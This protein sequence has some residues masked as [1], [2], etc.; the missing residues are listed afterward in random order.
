MLRTKFRVKVLIME[1]KNC[2]QGGAGEGQDPLQSRPPPRDPFPVQTLTILQVRN[3]F[4]KEAPSSKLKRTPPAGGG[5]AH[6][7]GV[8]TGACHD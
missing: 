1:A 5:G 2:R 4:Q 6:E 7:P 8:G 3:W